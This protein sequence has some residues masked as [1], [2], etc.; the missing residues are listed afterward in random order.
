MEK[1]FVVFLVAYVAMWFQR[2]GLCHVPLSP[3]PQFTMFYLLYVVDF[4]VEN[5]EISM[6]SESRREKFM[7]LV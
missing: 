2:G 3:V 6:K 4:L 5:A 7:F 1:I